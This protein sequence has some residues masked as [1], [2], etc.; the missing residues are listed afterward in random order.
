MATI[1]LTAAEAAIRYLAAQY[2]ELD[3]RTVPL[4]GGV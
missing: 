4:F 3:G 1:R 2:T